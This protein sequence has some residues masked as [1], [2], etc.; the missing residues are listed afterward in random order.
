[1]CLVGLFHT[2]DNLATVLFMVVLL[3]Q[4]IDPTDPSESSDGRVVK[5]FAS[6][7]VDLGL[8]PSRVK[9]MTVK[10]VSASLL[11]A[12]HCRNSVENQPASLLVPLRKALSG[13]TPSWCRR[14]GVGNLRPAERMRSA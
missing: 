14:P 1:M 4:F 10:L 6:G 8:I 5:A 9:P 3:N 2:R 7:A 12:Q 11:D 13:I